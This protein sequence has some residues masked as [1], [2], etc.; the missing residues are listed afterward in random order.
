MNYRKCI[1]PECIIPI[2]RLSTSVFKTGT[3]GN[4][5]PVHREKLSAC[6]GVCPAGEDI[7]VFITMAAEADYENAFLKITEEN[8]LP[9]VCGRVCYHPCEEGCLRN[10]SD[11]AVAV[12]RAERFIGDYGLK[13]LTFS[14]P[15]AAS[16]FSIAVVGSGPAGLSC[17]FHGRRLG[18]D[19]T[20]YEAEKTLGGMLRIGIPAYRLPRN[21][22][23]D[24]IEMILDTGIQT[25]TGFRL[26]RPGSWKELD[27]FDAVFLAMGAHQPILPNIPGIDS[28]GVISGLD[29]LREV[30]LGLRQ[31]LKGPVVV[32]GGGN[33]AIDAARVSL[34]LGNRV[35]I[36]YRRSRE[37]MPASP[38][39]VMDAENEGSELLTQ[40]IPKEIGPS[41]D[42]GLRIT[43][44]KTRPA[45]GDT[46]GRT[47]FEPIEDTAFDISARTLVIA[48]GQSIREPEE[49]GPIQIEPDGITVTPYLNTCDSKFF[50]GGDVVAGPRRVCD[51]IGLGKLAA[52]SMHH[53]LS[54]K[55]IATAW[56]QVKIGQNQT[57][58][59]AEYLGG[60]GKIKS[61]LQEPVTQMAEKQVWFVPSKRGK[62]P[63]IPPEQAVQSFNEVVGDVDIKELETVTGRC[64]SCGI[65]IGCDRCYL[66]CPEASMLPPDDDH[67]EYQGDAEFCKGCGVCAS[68]CPRGVITMIED[69]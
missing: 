56:P 24:S 14:Q 52:F 4:Y 49:A 3:W 9:S 50:A 35:K 21:I 33:T 28:E 55:E 65:C 46:A 44:L 47:V 41:T 27:R 38:E 68:V 10:D 57:F 42:G 66:F 60:E 17:A 15:T 45:G 25:N 22:L 12:H 37:E 16:G 67:S 1:D 11:G 19:V 54:G 2:S 64:F 58:S 18:H 29:L 7:P 6:R 61:R 39:E 53:Y 40:A 26:G 48:T 36:L 69:I 20:L 59:M 32:I 34:R 43:C 13:N 30:N 8:P 31:E 63:K 23:D 5:L 62:P 51:A